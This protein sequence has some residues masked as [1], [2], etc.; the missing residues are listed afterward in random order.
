VSVLPFKRAVVKIFLEI[1]IFGRL[2]M[3]FFKTFACLRALSKRKKPFKN[4]KNKTA[5]QYL[6]FSL[7]TCF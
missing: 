1:L 7:R 5:F 3:L 6:A 4:R 2:K